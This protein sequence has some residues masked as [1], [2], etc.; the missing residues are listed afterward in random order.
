MV[1]DRQEGV[2]RSPPHYRRL[3]IAVTTPGEE[4]LE[5]L[6]YQVVTPAAEH[7]PP[8]ASYIETMLAVARAA[9]LSA[10]YVAQISALAGGR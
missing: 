4:R 3:E 10:A 2:H 9:G 7:V 1:L 5:C 6:A 8:A